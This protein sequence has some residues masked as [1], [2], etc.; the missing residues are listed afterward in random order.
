MDEHDRILIQH[1]AAMAV[2]ARSAVIAVI[3]GTFGGICLGLAVG[4]Q[5]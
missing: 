3:S 5:L 2:R 1:R 4:L